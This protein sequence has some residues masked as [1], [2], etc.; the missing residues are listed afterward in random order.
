[1]V[2]AVDA[3]R[4]QPHVEVWLL[5]GALVGLGFYTT[6]VIGPK[7]V[8]RRNG[9]GS[10]DAEV[11]TRRQRRLFFA[12]VVTLWVASDW[13]MHDVA[14]EYLYA[15]H[16]FQHLLITLVFPPLLLLA[17]PVSLSPLPAPPHSQPSGRRGDRRCY[18]PALLLPSMA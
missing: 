8:G 5:V 3:G 12:A 2:A 15:V 4:F 18:P 10:D 13:P 17:V 1:M 7:V 14:E 16:M 6:R 9:S 11:V